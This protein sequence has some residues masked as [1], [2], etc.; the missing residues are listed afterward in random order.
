MS[1]R[2]A[3]ITRFEIFIEN[4]A[5]IQSNAEVDC[6]SINSV[7]FNQQFTNKCKAN[8]LLGKYVQDVMLKCKFRSEFSIDISLILSSEID[9][10]RIQDI[11]LFYQLISN[12]LNDLELSFEFTSFSIN[13]QPFFLINGFA[14][15][16]NERINLN[17]CSFNSNFQLNNPSCVSKASPQSESC[18]VAPI[19]PFDIPI[20]IVGGI[21]AKPN[22]WP[23]Q[24]FLFT[25]ESSCGGSLINNEWVLTAAHCV[26]SNAS[27]F[28]VRVLLGGHNLSVREIGSIVLDVSRIIIHEFYDT[29]EL[30]NDI[31]LLK[32]SRPVQFSDKIRPI[33]LA[34][35]SPKPFQHAIA[36]GWV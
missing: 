11:K 12:V 14:N 8:P 22:S 3:V 25:Q 9:L 21:E 28:K 33:C 30:F 26:E 16:M 4:F 35:T 17:K 15:N 23:W 1:K 20:R 32:L 13:N 31:A 19:Q 27:N 6:F 7:L 34:T 10:L 18:G 36:T 5:Q 29:N 2:G 24:V